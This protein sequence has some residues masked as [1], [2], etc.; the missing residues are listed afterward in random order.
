[1]TETNGKI[2][3]DAETAADVAIMA[4]RAI[5]E[6]GVTVVR[7]ARELGTDVAFVRRLLDGKADGIDRQACARLY[8]MGVAIWRDVTPLEA[9]DIESRWQDREIEQATG[10][11]MV[12]VTHPMTA[13]VRGYMGRLRSTPAELARMMGVSGNFLWRLLSGETRRIRARSYA[14]LRRHVPALRGRPSTFA[15]TGDRQSSRAR[16]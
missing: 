8:A 5:M 3:F 4:K 15:T 2:K 12:A 6:R 10:G 13:A 9:A 14:I 11:A 16:R 7:F 1:M